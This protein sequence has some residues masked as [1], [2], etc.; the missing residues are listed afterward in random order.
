MAWPL[1]S[2]LQFS[3][4]AEVL[5]SL[6]V[7]VL[8]M[9]QQMI[10]GV[11]ASDE[12]LA[13]LTALNISFMGQALVLAL[14]DIRSVTCRTS[15]IF[16]TN[17]V[18]PV[19]TTAHE[20]RLVF[21]VVF[22]DGQV[23]QGQ[24]QGYLNMR[25]GGVYLYVAQTNG[26]FKALWIPR[27]ALK[28][29][30][31]DQP[32]TTPFPVPSLAVPPTT[33]NSMGSPKTGLATT[34]SELAL[35]LEDARGK[36]LLSLAHALFELHM[37]DQAKLDELER[38][39]S[40]NMRAYIDERL[41]SSALFELQLEHARAR[42]VKTPEVNADTFLIEPQAVVKISWPVAAR[43]S[44]V[45]LGMIS[46]TLYVASSAPMNRELQDRLSMIANCNVALVWASKVQIDLRISKEVQSRPML[47]ESSGSAVPAR[48]TTLPEA[49]VLDLQSLLASAQNEIKVHGAE[50]H[51]NAV[52]ERSSVVLLVKRIILDANKQKASDIHIE[53]NPGE[54]ISRVRFRIDGDLEEYLRLPADLRAALVSRIKVMSKLDIS[55]RRR[56]QDGKINF[57][58]FSNTK[59][60]LRVAI[61]PTHNNLED[62][63]MRLLASS[64]PIP[65]AQLG[66]SPRDAEIVKRLSLHPYGLL[67]ACGPTGSGKTTTLH[68][69]LSEINT[70]SRKIWTAEDPIEITQAGLRQLQVNPKIGLTFA[71]AM[72]AFLRA[73]P[74]VIMI[75][76]VRDEETARICVEASLTGH[77]VFST[78]HT[79]GAAESV[80]RL[81][82]LGMDPMNFGDSLIGIVAQ[83]LVRGLCKVC[84]AP[85]VLSDAEFEALV[86]EYI[87]GTA[88]TMEEGRK[89]LLTSAASFSP[90]AAADSVVSI[91]EAVG[92]DQCAGRGYKG[93]MG[94]YEVLE[95]VGDMKHKIQIRAPTS[96]ILAEASS[97]GM[98]TLRQDALEKVVA[99]LIDLKQAR[100]L[101]A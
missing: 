29:I 26:Q 59:L 46:G 77:L 71:A 12:N 23:M 97:A 79:N 69:L 70:D 64:K 21:H 15:L 9:D 81:L 53:T 85:K 95:N 50:V 96:E 91:R 44:V 90:D 36:P 93:R 86:R 3:A 68:S 57:A 51:S 24:T 43:H 10:R 54:E 45:P 39:G 37:L 31:I 75:G 89:R 80:V 48:K 52:D 40:V 38:E 42:M 2:K 35:L 7:E 30:R 49:T 92:C 67:L 78:L 25:G 41:S 83:R 101:Y 56:P 84:A 65:L 62:V 98:R 16:T 94:I 99:G 82:D 1:P 17:P 18:T 66:F 20:E 100:T 72:R 19:K 4:P 28:S 76:E 73:D 47:Q 32:D 61:L 55:E 33:K 74:D 88:L 63:V 13:A 8:L 5:T 11:M 60:E 14:S 87:A 22:V 34:M 27:K 58:D 6:P